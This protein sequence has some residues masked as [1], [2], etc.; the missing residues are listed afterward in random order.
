MFKPDEFNYKPM[1]STRLDINFKVVKN[2]LK[3]SLCFVLKTNIFN[4]MFDISPN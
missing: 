3:C 2:R 1:P 4:D